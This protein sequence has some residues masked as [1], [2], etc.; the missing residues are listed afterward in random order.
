MF[1]PLACIFIS[2]LR[3]CVV[4]RFCREALCGRLFLVTESKKTA[5]K[6]ACEA[7]GPL[8][9]SGQ[10]WRDH[11]LFWEKTIRTWGALW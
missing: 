8:S 7:Q 11:M 4:V 9:T 5:R 1:V 2:V 3:R 10:A 6:V